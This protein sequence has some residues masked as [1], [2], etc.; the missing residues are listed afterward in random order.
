MGFGIRYLVLMV[1]MVFSFGWYVAYC[2][3]GKSAENIPGDGC[4]EK[5][6]LQLQF[7]P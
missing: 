1:G 6:Q 7:I 5:L 2:W 4:V 3:Y